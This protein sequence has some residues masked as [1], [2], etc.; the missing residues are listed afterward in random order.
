[1]VQIQ[2]ETIKKILSASRVAAEQDKN[3][4]K[5]CDE[6]E[7]SI[8]ETLSKSNAEEQQKTVENQ[9]N[10]DVQVAESTESQITIRENDRRGDLEPESSV[11]E[12]NTTEV[13]SE[14]SALPNGRKLFTYY[15]TDRK[16]DGPMQ[17][18]TTSKV[19]T[20]V[21]EETRT[22]TEGQ[23]IILIP[24]M[25]KIV[26]DVPQQMSNEDPNRRFIENTNTNTQSQN[27][28]VHIQIATDKPVSVTTKELIT[29]DKPEPVQALVLEKVYSPS[30]QFLY[31]MYRLRNVVPQQEVITT[32][33]PTT[34]TSA[35]TT[36][37]TTTT[38]TSTTTIKPI[39]EPVYTEQMKFV[40]RV[41]LTDP[42]PISRYPWKFD[43]FAYYPKDL[44]PAYI[45]AP[46][47]YSPTYHMIRTLAVPNGDGQYVLQD[48]HNPSLEKK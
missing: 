38:T 1:M 39:P 32:T 21:T 45:N 44:Q 25:K 3:I 29:T 41:P 43:K 17:N 10:Q 19:E 36:K 15:T 18:I 5:N 20:T 26:T 6:I 14:K 30:G 11:T 12:E 24:C 47:P 42:E 8:K 4:R 31:Y 22:Y 35:T 2:A 13:V 40:V 23:N 28:N 16:D 33:A 48:P 46:V 37:S 34:T 27:Q 9:E 7:S